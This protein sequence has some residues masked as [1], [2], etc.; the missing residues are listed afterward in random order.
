MIDSYNR[1]RAK[2]AELNR[3]RE[4]LTRPNGVGG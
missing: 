2:L 1:Q 3:I 4:H